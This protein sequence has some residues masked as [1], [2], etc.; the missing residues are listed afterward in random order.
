MMAL[1]LAVL[2]VAFEGAAAQTGTAALAACQQ[3]G[4]IPPQ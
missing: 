2:A 3:A 1:R 4:P